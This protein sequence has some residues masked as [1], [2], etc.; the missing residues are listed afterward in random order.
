MIPLCACLCFFHPHGWCLDQRILF[1]WIDSSESWKIIFMSH[2]ACPINWRSSDWSLCMYTCV[3]FTFFLCMYTCVYFTFLCL[4]KG[5][6]SV[7]LIFSDQFMGCSCF[8][9]SEFRGFPTRMVYL[10]YISC[11]RYTIL[12]G[13]PRLVL[14]FYFFLPLVPVGVAGRHS[15]LSAA[16][17]VAWRRDIPWVWGCQSF[18]HGE[19]NK[20]RKVLLTETRNKRC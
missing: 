10:C 6:V 3:Y 4:Q 5:R 19:K 14:Y 16:R 20:N 8:L 9:S 15:C 17:W 7:E 12:A 2:I 13:N 11:L 1:G 18:V